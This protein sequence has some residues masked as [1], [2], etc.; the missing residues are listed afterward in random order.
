MAS[1]ARTGALL[2][3]VAASKPGGRLLEL[4]TGTGVATAWLLDGMDVGAH[5]TSVD[6]DPDVQGVAREILADDSRLSLVTEDA[7]SFLK[8][9]PGASFDFVFADALAGKYEGLHEALRVV[10]PGGFYI[11]D[12]LLPQP[13]WPEGHASKVPRLVAELTASP[14]FSVVSLDW[15]SGLLVA[16]RSA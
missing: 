9:Q 14:G 4:G 2:R 12:D 15:S 8:R 6:T 3:T 5:L 16:V 13:N 10:G 1:E 7:L 11:V